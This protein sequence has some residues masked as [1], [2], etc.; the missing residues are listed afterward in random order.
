[1]ELT[2]FSS[3]PQRFLDKDILDHGLDGFFTHVI[4]SVHDKRRM[5]S[6]LVEKIGFPREETLLV[7]DMAHDIET[8]NLA[9]L[10][11]AAVLS[12][13]HTRQK[14]E[15]KEPNFMLKDIRDLKFI[16]E[17]CYA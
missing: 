13:Y 10:P 11:T 5:I 15:E 7:G 4:G 3:H 1:M 12:G 8:G 2:V 6:D 9:G 17:G 14:L 16:V